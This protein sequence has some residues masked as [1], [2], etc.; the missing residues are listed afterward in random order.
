MPKASSAPTNTPSNLNTNYAIA[1]LSQ[2]NFVSQ[3]YALLRVKFLGLKMC[4]CKK[5]DKYQVYLD[6]IQYR[7]VMSTFIRN[8]QYTFYSIYL[9]SRTRRNT[10]K[11]KSKY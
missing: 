7:S 1:V 8:R 4:Q 5:M 10:R 11:L 9:H 2:G 6:A 3:I